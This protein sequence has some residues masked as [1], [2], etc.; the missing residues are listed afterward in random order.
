MSRLE[1]AP[2]LNEIKVTDIEKGI[3][4]FIPKPDKVVSFVLLKTALK[5]AGYALDTSDLTVVGT[6]AHDAAGWWLV[7]EPTGQRFALV[8]PTLERLLDGMK[9]GATVEITG[10]WKTVG[11][12][13]D[14]HEA[15]APRELKKS[16]GGK[17]AGK[18]I[19]SQRTAT[20]S[21][22]DERRKV[23][24]SY[25]SFDVGSASS[26]QNFV[27][28][29]NL[30]PHIDDAVLY[31]EPEE[32]NYRRAD[33]HNETSRTRDWHVVDSSNVAAS[34]SHA[35]APIRTT[36]PGL[37]VYRGGAITPRLSFIS[38]DLGALRVHRQSLDLSATYTPTPHLQLEAQIPYSRTSFND[39]VTSGAGSGWGNPTLWGKYRFF[40]QLQTWGDRQAAVRFGVELPL[41]DKGAPDATQLQATPFVRQQLSSINGGLTAHLDAAY[42]Q[43]RRR[44]IFGG[45]IEGIMRS[46]RDGFRLGHELR[47]NTDLEYV[48]F[49]L[50]Y[51]RPTGELF[52]I[53]E[54]SYV[55]RG[56]GRVNETEV[57]GSSSNEYFIAP[58]LQYVA[59]TRMVF[60][61]SWQFPAF[62]RT[63]REV[64][65]TNRNVLF[66]IKYLF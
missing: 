17:V 10:D 53:L 19:S 65:R 66:G 34:A 54:T 9:A 2:K 35:S 42:S 25:A 37:T 56:R 18:A 48:I 3:G 57:A 62:R 31:L 5:K 61:T 12:G 33:S 39:G 63:G 45:N 7:A 13:K 60:E 36:S 41:G 46:E 55:W 4:V 47:F 21:A 52:A 26:A 32:N 43:A 20:G 59:T 11:A 50:R 64:L 14:T 24:A 16:D 49:P 22:G 58:G 51:R 44:L 28:S 29:T 38:Q 27:A 8:S 15:I 40:R 1:F 6:L 23:S 30:S